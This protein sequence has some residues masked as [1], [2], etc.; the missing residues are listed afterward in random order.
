M[1]ANTLIIKP[2]VSNFT[3]LCCRIK[4]ES[5]ELQKA[6]FKTQWHLY[7]LKRKVSRLDPVD[8][9][10]FEEIQATLV[11]DA[12]DDESIRDLIREAADDNEEQWTTDDESVSDEDV[13]E[14]EL[15]RDVIDVD[16]CLFCGKISSSMKDNV[17]HMNDHGFFIPEERYLTDLE[18]LL[19]YLGYKV[20]AGACCLWCNKQAKSRHGAR[21]HMLYKDH[22]K[23]NY[24]QNKAVEEFSD[25]YDYS[26]QERFEMKPLDQ[27]V[28][29]KRRIE[30]NIV[31]RQMRKD[32]VAEL[33]RNR[34]SNNKQL[35]LRNQHNLAS[36]YNPRLEMK[37]Q[38]IRSK[39]HLRT[40]M[41]N[42][43]TMRGRIRQQNPM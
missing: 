14:E 27:L 6:H 3:C 11:D 9:E 7:N 34:S 38:K 18:G 13:M 2:V 15:L 31:A 24:D 10:Y 25:F 19:I 40:G 8:L 1:A 39:L 29:S 23:I 22:C 12:R 35:I 16:S 36:N 41:A 42:N 26:S 30:R 20:G 32:A 37:M 5:V 21:L 33:K 28:M 4:L 43:Q 17:E